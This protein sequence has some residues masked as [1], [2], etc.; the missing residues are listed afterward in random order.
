MSDLNLIGIVISGCALGVAGTSAAFALRQLKL[1]E[2]LQLRDFEATVVCELESYERTSEGLRYGLK[3]TN[4]GPAVARDV[5]VS[6]VEWTGDSVLGMSL[7]EAGVAPA[8]LRGE[9]RLVT[10][11]LLAEHAAGLDD[12]SRSIEV[13]CDYYDDNGVRN[14][15]L[16]FV[17]EGDLVLTPPQLPES[18]SPRVEAGHGRA[19]RRSKL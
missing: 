13:M 9:Q 15:R 17:V 1:A 6:L 12:R 7:A 8:M 18:P 4:A 3:V 10:L 19:T 11:E 14:H 16:A 5:D 2:R